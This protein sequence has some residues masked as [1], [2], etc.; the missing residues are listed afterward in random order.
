MS[1]VGQ[2]EKQTQARVV[3]LFCG[4]LGYDYL[5]NRI[6]RDNRNIEPELLRAWLIKQGVDSLLIKRAIHALEKVAG[7]S[8]QG[9]CRFF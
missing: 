3:A 5:G 7:G 2:I 6:D 4:Q 9:R 1:S 8:C